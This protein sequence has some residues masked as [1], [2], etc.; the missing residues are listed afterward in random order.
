MTTNTPLHNPTL[1]KYIRICYKNCSPKLTMSKTFM[2]LSSDTVHNRSPS[3]LVA[4]PTTFP[5]WARKCFTNSIPVS[6]FFQNLTCPSMLA[7]IRKSVL[8]TRGEG[9]EWTMGQEGREGAHC[10]TSDWGQHRGAPK[11]CSVVA[12]SY[13]Y[14]GYKY[15]YR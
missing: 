15:E 14:G 9:E 6:C 13:T 4:M 8:S 11:R 10:S 2:D 12:R 3:E 5:K 1:Q 7:V